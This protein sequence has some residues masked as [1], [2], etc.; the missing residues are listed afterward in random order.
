MLSSHHG[1]YRC[2][3]PVP[4]SLCGVLLMSFGMNPVT[5][6]PVESIRYLPTAPL[7]FAS[8]CGNF[9]D[10]EFSRIRADSH[11]PPATTTMRARTWLSRAVFLSM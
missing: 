7:E 10:F 9:A 2:M 8:P 1:V 3:P 11:A 4:S 6:V 5:L